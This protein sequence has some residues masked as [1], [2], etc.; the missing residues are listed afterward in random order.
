MEGAIEGVTPL[1][2]FPTHRQ[3]RAVARAGGDISFDYR[4]D[5][6]LLNAAIPLP[7][8]AGTHFVELWAWDDRLIVVSARSKAAITHAAY[9]AAPLMYQLVPEGLQ[10]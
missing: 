10:T 2:Q 9:A 5:P 6:R 4:P 8:F 7:A 3:E 1:L